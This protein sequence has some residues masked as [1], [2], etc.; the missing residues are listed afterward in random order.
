MDPF[1]IQFHDLHPKK[2]P[3]SAARPSPG[4]GLDQVLDQD[5]VLILPLVLLL[6]QDQVLLLLL[7]LMLLNTESP[8]HKAFSTETPQY[9]KL[10]GTESPGYGKPSLRKTLSPESPQYGKPSGWKALSMESP[11]YGKPS[12]RKALSPES[13]EY[14]K[15]SVQ[16]AFITESLQYGE[17][18]VRKALSTESPQ[19]V[20]GLLNLSTGQPS[21]LEKSPG[22][23]KC[24]PL[25]GGMRKKKRN[26]VLRWRLVKPKRQKHKVFDI[27][28][29]I[30]YGFNKKITH[31]QF[32]DSLQKVPM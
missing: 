9:R 14:G 8:V 11:Q 18:S 20:P 13:P 24:A 25:C 29:E 7:L 27:F 1:Q 30:I 2:C 22:Q 16:K 3:G 4:R 26:P 31:A 23:K 28:S 10:F 5:Q 19:D 6:D 32:R 12:V 17:P 21:F 15:P